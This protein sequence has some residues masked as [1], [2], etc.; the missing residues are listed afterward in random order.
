MGRPQKKTRRLWRFGGVA[1]V[2]SAAFLLIGSALFGGLPPSHKLGAAAV[3][4][5]LMG[6]LVA[7]FVELFAA[8]GEGFQRTKLAELLAANGGRVT[9]LELA[10][11]IGGDLDAARCLLEAALE[12]QD[13]EL[14]LAEDGTEV[15]AFRGVHSRRQLA[16]A[17]T[18]DQVVGL[19]EHE[20]SVASRRR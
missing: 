2:T 11:K 9:V 18:L 4:A 10:S 3:G 6:F 16:E 1:L 19:V 14:L 5:A 12:R 17:R 20:E 8:I 13:A 7:G 15:F